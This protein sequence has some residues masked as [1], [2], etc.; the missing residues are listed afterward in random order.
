MDHPFGASLWIQTLILLDVNN[1]NFIF[2]ETV[3][4]IKKC[5]RKINAFYNTD[6]VTE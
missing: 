5:Y 1:F 6:F 3:N 4:V 2:E